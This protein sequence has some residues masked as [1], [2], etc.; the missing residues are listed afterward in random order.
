MAKAAKKSGGAKKAAGKR[1]NRK[2]KRTYASYISKVLKNAAKAKLTLSGTS[3]KILNSL[4]VD[5]VDRLATEAASIARA[6]KKR[7][8]GS[9]E[10]QTAVRV[11]LP[12][13]L[14]K[15]SMAEATKAVAKASA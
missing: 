1:S 5:L 6:N 8:L 2:P 10:L 4:V 15:H 9:R 7:T 3:M 11:T 12:N 14:A 13:E